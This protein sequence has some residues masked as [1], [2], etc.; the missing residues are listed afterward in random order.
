[1]VLHGLAMTTE[2]SIKLILDRLVF[3]KSMEWQY[4]QEYRLYVPF[5]IKEDQAFATLRYH[6]EEL[7]SIFLGCRM[8][9]EKRKA[10]VELA[11]KINPDVS[12]KMTSIHPREFALDFQEMP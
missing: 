9:K 6:P 1:M 10:I 3:T 5:L 2:E 11:R 8:T 4:E 7:T 12:I